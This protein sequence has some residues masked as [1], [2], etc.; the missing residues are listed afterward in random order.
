MRQ[1]QSAL[2]FVI[3]FFASSVQPFAFAQTIDGF[4]VSRSPDNRRIEEQFRTVP[5]PDSAREHLRRWTADP[6]LAGTKEGSG[7]A[8]CVRGQMRAPGLLAEPKGD[9]VRVH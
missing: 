4:S 1:T 7:T 5:A 8:V 9:E 2:A 6:H 3:I